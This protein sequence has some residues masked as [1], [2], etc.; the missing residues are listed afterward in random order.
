MDEIKWLENGQI[1]FLDKKNKEHFIT[2]AVQKLWLETFE[3]KNLNQTYIPKQNEQVCK[4][5]K[6]SLK[7]QFGSLKKLVSQHREQF[8]VH[9]K[10]VLDRPDLIVKIGVCDYYLIKKYDEKS[11][12]VNFSSDKGDYLI[13]LSNGVRTKNNVENKIKAGKILY[14]VQN[15]GSM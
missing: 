12:F 14:R 2:Q 7:L 13:S 9:I 11:F 1:S 4:V 3:L 6:K 15:S 8:I 5:L 10:E